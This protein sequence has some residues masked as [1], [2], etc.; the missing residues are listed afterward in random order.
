MSGAR[1]TWKLILAGVLDFLTIFVVAGYLIGKLTG[2]LTQ[3]GFK[4]DGWP[5]LLLFAIV[6]AYFPLGKRA[7]GTLW[8]RI[9]GVAP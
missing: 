4:L 9:F 8:R 2:G 6:I 5:A 3:D 7:G 1:P